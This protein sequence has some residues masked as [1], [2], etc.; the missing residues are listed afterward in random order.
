M[1]SDNKIVPLNR[2]SPETGTRG[3]A[4]RGTAAEATAP[5]Q[6]LI[7]DDEPKNL[8][9]LETILDDP[10]YR[11]IRAH[12][13]DEALLALVAEQFAVLILD[14]RMPGMTGFELAEVIKKRKKTAQVPIIFLTAY[15]SEDQHVLEGY[16]SGAVDYLH[17]PVNPQI[18]RSKVA[19]FAE[20][21][22]KSR[23]IASANSALLEE[24]KERRH[25]EEQLR[26]F[27]ET[28]EA[29]VAARTE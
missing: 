9:V 8:V 23:D 7:V 28:L 11:L 19:V 15:Y 4:T 10:D 1:N 12:S 27:N 24:V 16:G 25:A 5:I 20:L 6:I 26:Q 21:H 22:R 14:I 3:R 29:R 17:K 2:P 18:L 13:A